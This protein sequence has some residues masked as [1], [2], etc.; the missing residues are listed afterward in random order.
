MLVT[1]GQA[2]VGVPESH[3]ARINRTTVMNDALNRRGRVA[4]DRIEDRL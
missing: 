2:A 4:G 3:A 1:A